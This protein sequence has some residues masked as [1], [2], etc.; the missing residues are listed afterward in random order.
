MEGGCQ[1]PSLQDAGI[2]LEI[3]HFHHRDRTTKKFALSFRLRNYSRMSGGINS[4]SD[5]RKADP[6]ILE[7]LDKCDL[8][9]GNC[10]NH[11]ENCGLDCDGCTR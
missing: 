4:I 7:E 9:C 6:E 2:C 8:L 10:H 5:L 1:Y 3:Y 11:L